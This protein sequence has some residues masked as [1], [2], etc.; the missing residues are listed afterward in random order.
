MFVA[1]VNSLMTMMPCTIAVPGIFLKAILGAWAPKLGMA[2]VTKAQH[3]EGPMRL[4]PVT[5]WL[6]HMAK[7]RHGGDEISSL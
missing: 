2:H 5:V 3:K 4:R 7:V 1:G 6:A